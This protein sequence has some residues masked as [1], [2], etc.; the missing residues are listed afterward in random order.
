MKRITLVR[1]GETFQNRYRMV[2]GSDPTQGRLT[3]T[4]I[5]QA[6]LLGRNLADRPFDKVY[7][8]PRVRRGVQGD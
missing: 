7:C 2:Q 4:G 5:R 1:H 8:S 3:E 6:E